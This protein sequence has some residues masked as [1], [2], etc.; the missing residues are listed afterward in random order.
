MEGPEAGEEAETDHDK[1]EDDVLEVGGERAVLHGVAEG[2]DVERS[3]ARLDVDGDNGN[4][5]EHTGGD[6][7]EH[8]LE[9][10]VL[11]GAEEVGFLVIAGGAVGAQRDGADAGS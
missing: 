5:D 7:H 10:A 8:E 4:P 1:E 6:D 9:R 2:E 11:L 3:R